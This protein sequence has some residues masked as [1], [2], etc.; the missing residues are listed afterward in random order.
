M[1]QQDIEMA[2]QKAREKHPAFVQN[3]EQAFCVLQEEVGEAA[4]VVNERAEMS[5]KE[6][7]EQLCAEL[8]DIVAVC[9][10]MIDKEY[11]YSAPLRK[12]YL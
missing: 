1:T 2:L 6:Y 4:K 9:L 8:Y 11:S 3:V 7:D 12:Y 5:Q 10:R